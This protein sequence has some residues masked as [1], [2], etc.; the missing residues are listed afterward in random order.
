MY[1]QYALSDSIDISESS[2]E[3]LDNYTVDRLQF[4]LSRDNWEISLGDN[5]SDKFALITK[6]SSV[7]M[8]GINMHRKMVELLVYMQ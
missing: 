6:L 4:Y 7:P 3:Y 2:R 8:F 1:N 5:M